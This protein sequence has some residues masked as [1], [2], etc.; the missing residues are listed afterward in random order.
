MNESSPPPSAAPAARGEALIAR[1]DAWLARL[2]AA[3]AR[4]LPKDAD[5]LGQSGRMANLAL[6][7]AVA[8]GVAL[9]VWYSS[10]LTQAH[11]S[12]AALHAGGLGAWVRAL[13][14]YSSDLVM[15]FLLVHA[16]RIFFARKFT[17]ARW[18]PW[19]SGV[20]LVALIWFI[21][22]TGFWLVWDQ[23]A[24]KLATESMRVLDALP[25]FGEPLGRLF[26]T[27]RLVPSLL[28]FVVFFTHMLLPLGIATGLVVHLI[29]LNRVKL[30]PDRRLVV[31]FLLPLALAAWLVPAP[32]DA[33][34]AMAEKA[35][36][37]TVDAWYLSPLALSLR[38]QHSGAWLVLGGLFALALGVPWLLGRRFAPRAPE[39]G[40]RPSAAFQTVVETSRCHACTQCVQ[41]CPFDAVRMVP[42]SDG[43]RFTTQAWVDPT[44]CVGCAVCVGSCDSEAMHLPWFDAVAIE[45]RIEAEARAALTGGG[46]D[47]AVCVAMVAADACGGME[48]F[49][50][51]AWRE[52]LPDFQVH[53]VPTASWVRP[54]FVERLLAAGVARVLIVRDS[55]AE[56]SARYGNRWIA[57]RLAG[58][59]APSFRPARAGGDIAAEAWC[60]LDHDPAAPRRLARA[61]A[62]FARGGRPVVETHPAAWTLPRMAAFTALCA[63][64]LVF[65]IQLSHLR[66]DNPEPAGPELVFSFKAFGAWQAPGAGEVAPRDQSDRPVHMRGA[67]RAKHREPVRVR[68]IVDGEAEERVYAAKGLSRDGP[69]I[70]VWR[71]PLAPGARAVEIVLADENETPRRWAGVIEA[72]ERR[73]HVL[74]FDPA[75]GFREE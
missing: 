9:L 49:D 6:L 40:P 7:V 21:G 35:A 12:L 48:R 26:L 37:L 60:V 30:L 61:A 57:D 15:F 42:R 55:R 64:I 56:A 50:A 32:L 33:P 68:L 72:R 3:L 65:T 17:G 18:L 19:V 31:A 46:A 29:R 70:A 39:A 34:A 2:D 66:V 75:E 41:D 71:L 62:A 52:R 36:A 69:A 47:V 53:A 59:R 8:S 1:V 54:K 74:T 13:H 22:W 73:L 4:V 25:I 5:P 16:L 43:K 27:D 14:R 10:S 28:F 63:L 44:R 24:Q 45:P 58:T 23:P 20:G 11:A 38:L 67:P 51:A